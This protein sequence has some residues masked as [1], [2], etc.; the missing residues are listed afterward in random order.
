MKINKL[1][2]MGVLALGAIL[3]ACS[4]DSGGGGGGE[5]IRKISNLSEFNTWWQEAYGA[6]HYRAILTAD[7]DCEGAPIQSTATYT[8]RHAML[9]GQGFKITNFTITGQEKAALFSKAEDCEIK[10]VEFDYI[11]VTG[12]QP[13]VLFSE[14]NSSTIENVTIGEH[15]TVGDGSS[16]Y[17]GGLVAKADK[18]TVISRCTNNAEVKGGDY[19][20]GIVGYLYNSGVEQCSNYGD[21]TGYKNEHVGGVVG[22]AGHYQKESLATNKCYLA[23]LTNYGKVD[24]KSS[25]KVGGVVGSINRSAHITADT[26]K[27]ELSASTLVN[28]GDVSGKDYVGGVVGYLDNALKKATFSYCENRGSVTGE[29]YVAGIL[30]Y[31]KNEGDEF[32]SCKNMNNN[33]ST[34]QIEGVCHVA[35]IASRGNYATF[36]E[37]TMR[38]MLK[39]GTGSTNSRIELDGQ[40]AVGG[41]LGETFDKTA[42]IENCSN[43]GAI[44]GYRAQQGD[45]Y[46]T[47]TSIGGI[48]GLF[49][50]GSFKSNSHG[51]VVNGLNCVG[52]LIG[53]FIPDFDTSIS[54]CEVTGLVN[55]GSVY[56]GGM[57]GYVNG[58]NSNHKSTTI[59]NCSVMSENFYAYGNNFGGLIG[60]AIAGTST[61]S[62][63][64]TIKISDTTIVATI[65]YTTNADKFVGYN[66]AHSS[67]KLVV[68]IDSSVQEQVTLVQM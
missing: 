65:N 32:A 11:T 52:G 15:V 3:P 17:C 38:V 42:K 39:K 66:E 43:L 6:N 59:I 55:S 25:S 44:F 64:E 56:A 12:T 51:G 27:T 26:S 28:V 53:A 61:A 46:Y 48:V 16:D 14:V 62:H 21:I 8:A 36:C 50:G 2:V 1:F 63:F 68:L 9:D 35:G 57:I 41:I 7:I 34:N 67:G 47:A 54:S 5:Y 13:A 37:N 22:H 31:M 40:Y 18:K 23:H 20:G 19:V 49:Y 10:N 33:T 24:G 30:G 58:K 29:N 60:H 4:N 45:K